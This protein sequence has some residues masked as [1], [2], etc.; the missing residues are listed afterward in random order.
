MLPISAMPSAVPISR[1]VSFTA[2]ATPCFS[3][4]SELTMAF[5]ATPLTFFAKLM[6]V[7]SKPMMK[8]VAELC[9]K[10]LEDVKRAVEGA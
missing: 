7:L 3:R 5:Q 10:D 8:K 6:S 4:G 1:V 2:D 9:A